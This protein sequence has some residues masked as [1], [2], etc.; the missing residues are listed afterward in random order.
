MHAH[1]HIKACRLTLPQNG[2]CQ[3]VY[4]R[5][6]ADWEN[7]HALGAHTHTRCLLSALWLINF[8]DWACP[9]IKCSPLHLCHTQSAPPLSSVSALSPAPF[10]SSGLLIAWA[11]NVRAKERHLIEP[12]LLS[13]PPFLS[14]HICIFLSGSQDATLGF[15]PPTKSQGCLHAFSGSLQFSQLLIC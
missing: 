11:Q 14:L 3:L 15:S 6:E 8:P 7:A 1:T 9:T 10:G 2:M 5:S 4:I 13:F 12:R